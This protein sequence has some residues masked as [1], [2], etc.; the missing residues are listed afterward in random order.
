MTPAPRKPLFSSN[1]RLDI[2]I[3]LGLVLAIFIP[4]HQVAGH[5]FIEYDDGLYTYQNTYIIRGMCWDSIYWA[6]TNTDVANWHPLTWVSHLVDREVFGPHPGGYLLENVA[7]HALAACLCYLAFLKTTQSRLFAFSVALIFAVHPV[8]VENVA[9]MSERK[10]LLNAVFWFCAIVTYL[11]FVETRS[12]RSY[13]MTVIAH[14]LGLMSKAMSVTLPCTLILIHVLYLVYHVDKRT[15]SVEWKQCF[16][17]FILPVVPLLVISVYFSAVTMSAQSVAMPGAGY[18][19]GLRL[20][21]TLLSYRNYLEMFVHPTQLAHFYPLFGDDL[22]FRLAIPAILILSG[23]SLGAILLV[24]RKPQLLIGWC[25]FL[26]TMIPVIGLVQVGAQS[27]ADRYLY[28]PMLGLAF[29]FPVLFEELRSVRVYIR[30]AM[31]GASLMTLG[32]S[33]ILSTQIQVSYWKDGVTLFSHSLETTGDCVTNVFLLATAYGRMERYREMIAFIDSKIAVAGPVNR[34]KLSTLKAAAL[35]N[36]GKT[37]EAIDA[38]QA[39]IK[40][41]DASV[42]AYWTLAISS[43][44]LERIDDAVRYLARARALQ[45]AVNQTKAVDVELDDRMTELQKLLNS[46]AAFKEKLLLNKE[47]PSAVSHRH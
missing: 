47:N 20:I 26:G 39:A 28:I 14:L 34:G 13:G 18:S 2:L 12:F 31:I 37:E 5:R 45:K 4:Y 19:L 11:D 33:M 36:M 22:H 3:C 15:V 9:W 41:G 21:N 40:W 16:K 30:Q 6:F 24:R 46:V 43:F 23:I 29:I 42:S 32:T 8:N 17:T 10:S 25:W 1:Y 7:W 38:A 27:H 44:Q 35:S